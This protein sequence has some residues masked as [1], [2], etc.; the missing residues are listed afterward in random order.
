MKIVLHGY[1]NMGKL[2]HKLSLENNIEVVGIIDNNKKDFSLK[3]TYGDLINKDYDV[4]IDFSHFSQ[5]D[6][7]LDVLE[8]KPKKTLIATTKLTDA[9]LERI[10]KLAVNTAVFQD[11]NTSYGVYVLNETLKHMTK[12]LADY[13]IELIEKH[14]KYKVDAP[15]GTAV[16]LLDTIIK[17]RNLNAIYDYSK[18]DGK[19]EN[20]IGVH[21]I[22][23]G[24]IYGEH[25]INFGSDNDLLSIKHSALSKDLFAEGSLKISKKLCDK[26]YGL[27]KLEDVFN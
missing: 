24:N 18:V 14:H 4:L 26:D 17:Q 20:N 23:N 8:K 12:L 25:E 9:Q 15:S 13:D 27:F 1:G 19:K 22:R 3:M 11:Y 2:V 5:I 16:R 10:K 7:L 6:N 21:S